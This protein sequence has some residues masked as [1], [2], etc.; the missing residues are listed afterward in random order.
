[1]SN[2]ARDIVLTLLAGGMTKSAVADEIGYGRASVSRWI[3]EPGYNGEHVEAAVLARYNRFPCPH[4]KTE[5][6]PKDCAGYAQRSC[7]TSN[8]REVRHWRVCQTCPHK[9]DVKSEAKS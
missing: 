6:S 4:L 5:I 3:N 2:N 1:M 9:P 8:A 7:P